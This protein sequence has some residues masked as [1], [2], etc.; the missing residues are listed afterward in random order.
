YYLMPLA[1]YCMPFTLSL[2]AA[3]ARGFRRD[4]GMNPDGRIFLLVWAIS[5]FVFFTASAG[6]EMRYF[7][8]AIPPFLILLGIELSHFFCPRRA[9]NPRRD[10]AG[11]LAVAIGV[12]GVLGGAFFGL[13]KWHKAN[14]YHDWSQVWPSYVICTSVLTIALISS[15]WLYLR[16]R[17]HASFGMLIGG[18]WVFWLLMWSMMMPIMASERPARD[19]AEQLSNLR[20]TWPGWKDS[21]IFQVGSQDS[22]ITWYS[23]VRF[24]RVIDQLRLLEM[25]GG[26][27]SRAREIQLI[28]EEMVRRLAMDEPVLFVATRADYVTFLAEAPPHL[29]S[30]GREMPQSHLWLQTRIGPQGRHFVLFGNMPPP[31][32]EPALNPPSDRLRP[33]QGQKSS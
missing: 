15:A 19:F 4:S 16:R 6:K 3:I 24:P 8:P 23:D 28:G 18:M 22:R 29:A 26:K 33:P 2:P 30:Q 5:H 1:L 27:R 20:A 21:R 7:L 14:P 17:E 25:Q 32:P 13:I 12:P 9:A 10:R 11:F 31:W